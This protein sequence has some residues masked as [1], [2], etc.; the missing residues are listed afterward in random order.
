VGTRSYNSPEK[1]NGSDYD[2]S[3]LGV[4]FLN[5]LGTPLVKVVLDGC[6][7]HKLVES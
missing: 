4:Q 1:I 5:V 6:L 2:A 3:M 7:Y